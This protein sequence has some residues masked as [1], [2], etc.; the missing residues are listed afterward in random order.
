MAHL[1]LMPSRKRVSTQ[2]LDVAPNRTI[3]INVNGYVEGLQL[4]A[5]LDDS[6][7]PVAAEAPPNLCRTR[8]L[9][10]SQKQFTFLREGY[11]RID[12]RMDTGNWDW[13]RIRCANQKPA[14]AADLNAQGSGTLNLQVLWTRLPPPN[15]PLVHYVTNAR[16]LLEQHGF[17]LSVSPGTT[18]VASRL[19][20]FP[21]DIVCTHAGNLDDLS[22]V[23]TARQEYGI[24]NSLVVVLGPARQHTDANQDPGNLNGITVGSEYGVS[25]NPYVLINFNNV[26]ADGMTLVHEMG[27]AAGQVG[28]DDEGA[29][30]TPTRYHRAMSYGPRRNALTAAQVANFNQAFFRRA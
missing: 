12:L 24:A 28:H 4:L 15:H 11:F 14:E 5:T 17:R 13:L 8:A 1:E 30:V 16:M 20:D 3:T 23:V 29:N 18:Y 10:N 2:T 7:N 6:N 22:P 27:H 19:I 21:R 25:G 26:T 9:S